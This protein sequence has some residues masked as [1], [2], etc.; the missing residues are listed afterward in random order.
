MQ[1]SRS[2]CQRVPQQMVQADFYFCWVSVFVFYTTAPE[3]LSRRSCRTD[4]E[5]CTGAY[6]LLLFP[7]LHDDTEV[8]RTGKESTVSL[9]CENEGPGY[10]FVSA[11]SNP[12][13]KKEI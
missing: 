7:Q 8:Q 10:N 2:V 4:H 6:F 9:Y 3:S 11:L 1:K 13:I 5:C 12:L